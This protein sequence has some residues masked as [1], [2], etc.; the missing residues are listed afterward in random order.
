MQIN[1]FT[2]TSAEIAKNMSLSD[3]HK[4]EKKTRQ[5][6]EIPLA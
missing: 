6:G 1:P 5:I 3:A 4:A 2:L